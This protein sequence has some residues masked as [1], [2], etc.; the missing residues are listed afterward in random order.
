MTDAPASKEA[1]CIVIDVSEQMRP[2]L[3]D[4]LDAVRMLVNA[5]ILFHK[6]DAV[7]LVLHGTEATANAVAAEYGDEQYLHI[8]ETH[9]MAPVTHK[10]LESLDRT[11]ATPVVGAED[12]A[13]I[14]DSLCVGMFAVIAYVKKLKFAKRVILL[15]DGTAPANTEGEDGDQLGM[16][17]TQLKESQIKFEVFGIGMGKGSEGDADGEEAPDADADSD[18]DADPA[19]A[20]RKATLRVIHRLKAAIGEEYF[21]FER[22]SDPHKAF[23]QLKKRSMRPTTAFRGPIDIG[24]VCGLPIWSWRKVVAA[25]APSYAARSD[26]MSLPRRSPLSLPGVHRAHTHALA[27]SARDG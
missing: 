7:G 8:T 24:G 26:R 22:L 12:S 19:G 9:P 14:I 11:L 23:G 3:D 2:H 6:Q 18:A 15:T 21:K 5:K 13:D 27:P 1:C 4:A 10:T 16:I 17:A 20:A 25:T